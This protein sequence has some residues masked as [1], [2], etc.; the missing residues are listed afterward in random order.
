LFLV[1]L[2]IIDLLCLSLLSSQSFF[3][4]RPNCPIFLL[5]MHYITTAAAALGALAFV[6]AT[7][8]TE[9]NNAGGKGQYGSY[10][11][12]GYKQRVGPSGV[13]C[14]REYYDI[15]VTSEN[16]LFENVMSNANEVSV[17]RTL[18]VLSSSLET[19]ADFP[20]YRSRRS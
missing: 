13:K 10:G 15:S 11:N 3:D 20:I 5:S 16:T 1:R 19:L 8:L 2:P 18:L 4:H 12:P 14:N 17:T 6:Q 7:P 9:R